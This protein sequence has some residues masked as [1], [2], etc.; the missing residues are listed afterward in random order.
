MK[1][2]EN[3]DLILSDHAIERVGTI[4]S[5]QCQCHRKFLPP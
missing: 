3:R 5:I 1:T 4:P 2:H